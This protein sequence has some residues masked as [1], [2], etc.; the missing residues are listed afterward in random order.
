MVFHTPLADSELRTSP[1]INKIVSQKFSAGSLNI[2]L[3]TDLLTFLFAKQT[4][5]VL[6]ESRVIHLG[7][8]SENLHLEVTADSAQAKR[9]V[10]VAECHSFK[11]VKWL[12]SSYFYWI[13][14]KKMYFTDIASFFFGRNSK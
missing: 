4:L 14:Q 1:Q 9:A 3:Y 6:G 5:K 11:A 7:R 13:M 2:N 12:G 8:A 10:R